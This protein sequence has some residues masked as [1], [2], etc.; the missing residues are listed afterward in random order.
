MLEPGDL[1]TVAKAF[2]RYEIKTDA[3]F[4][5]MTTFIAGGTSGLKLKASDVVLVLATRSF[6]T[7]PDHRWLY[8]MVLAGFGWITS[9]AV[10]PVS[11]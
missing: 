9:T 8:V 4:N 6:H 10:C 3:E 7:R 5:V 2:D 11:P 1:C